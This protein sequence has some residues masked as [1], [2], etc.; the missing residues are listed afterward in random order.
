MDN[1]EAFH[2][3]T[4]RQASMPMAYPGRPEINPKDGLILAGD[5]GGTKCNLALIRIDSGDFQILRCKRYKTTDHDSFMES[6]RNITGDSDSPVEAACFGVAGV[7]ENGRVRGSNFAW[8]MDAAHIAKEMNIVKVMLINDLEANAY[9]LSALSDS[10]LETLSE[11]AADEGNAA[12]I[13]PGTGLG[14][15]GLYWDGQGYHP[16]ATEGGHCSFSPEDPAEVR[17]WNYLHNLYGHVSWERLLSG[18]GIYNIYRFLRA[19]SHASEPEWLSNKIREGDPP[20]V[21]STVALGK[22]DPVCV[23]T[24]KMFF[25]F[26][27]S[28]AAQLALKTKATSG[29]FI[30][31]GIVPQVRDMLDTQEFLHRFVQNGRMR[32]MLENIPVKIVLNDK[33]A[34]MGAAYYGAMLI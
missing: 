15:A 31:G 4:M 11:G 20:V 7:I 5:V 26:L 32:D 19:N 18:N 16:F 10:D 13:S 17:L 23:E 22:Q 6:I 33:A 24:L 28:E 21:I 3:R 9:G 25:R 12:I 14:E 8:A 1:R 29:I 30:G 34:L 2:L 27:A